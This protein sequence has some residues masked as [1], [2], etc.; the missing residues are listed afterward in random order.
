MALLRA[1]FWAEDLSEFFI[2][3]KQLGVQSIVRPVYGYFFFIQRSVAYAANVFPT[4][5]VPFIYALF[6]FLLNAFV[7]SYFSR[8]SFAKFIPDLNLRILLCLIFSLTGGTP[9]VHFNLANSPAHLTLFIGLI[10]LEQQ[11]GLKL[12]HVLAMIPLVGSSGSTVLLLPL[13]AYS[14][15]NTKNRNFF[16]LFLMILSFGMA[17]SYLTSHSDQARKLL[18]WNMIT[19]M[20]QAYWENILNRL[21]VLPF[22][23]AGLSSFV[24]RNYFIFYTVVV[25]FIAFLKFRI[26]KADLFKNDF[27]RLAAIFYLGMILLFPLVAVARSYGSDNSIFIKFGIP[28]WK[29]RY[30]FLPAVSSI[31]LWTVCLYPLFKDKDVFKA[32]CAKIIFI[33]IAFNSIIV[34]PDIYKRKNLNWPEGAMA[35]DQFVSDGNTSTSFD[36]Q[37]WVHPKGWLPSDGQKK[38]ELKK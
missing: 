37:E 14:F 25:L 27:I 4:I 19:R 24:M 31:L 9:E 29:N 2:A 36:M 1:E 8:T 21:F 33:I 34:W 32:R 15:W 35:I 22:F 5:L 10:V 38:I 11:K 17:N 18:N 7:A 12:W 16:F 26:F 30:S 13:I 3:A 23:G 28:L 6:S 20:P